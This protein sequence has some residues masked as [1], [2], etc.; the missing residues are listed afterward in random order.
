MFKNIL[1]VCVGNICRSPVGEK[2]LLEMLGSAITV[3]SAGVGA[4]KGKPIDPKMLKLLEKDGVNHLEH[5][6]RQLDKELASEA[7]LILVMENDHRDAIQ[8]IAPEAIGKVMLFSHWQ[9]QKNIADPYR[10][11]DEFF[12][13][14]Y[15]QIR[16]SANAWSSKLI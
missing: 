12:E 6:A 14:V 9:E 10:K 4:L 2:L 16:S 8:Q 15:Q 1:V 11:S 13:H 3:H 7:D 5:S